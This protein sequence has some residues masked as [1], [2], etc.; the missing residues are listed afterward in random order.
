[1]SVTSKGQRESPSCPRGTQA[2]GDAGGTC[3]RVSGPGLAWLSPWGRGRAHDAVSVSTCDSF[4]CVVGAAEASPLHLTD[5]YTET[6]VAALPFLPPNHGCARRGAAGE[7]GEHVA[8]YSPTCLTDTGTRALPCR[9][10]PG[11]F[12]GGQKPDPGGRG[13]QTRGSLLHPQSLEPW[14]PTGAGLMGIPVPPWVVGGGGGEG[15]GLLGPCPELPTPTSSPVSFSFRLKPFLLRDKI[16]FNVP[17][18]NTGDSIYS[19]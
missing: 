13:E 9:P 6:N 12:V 10:K 19:L 17:R 3:R 15:S 14:A 8:P 4:S 2:G 1:M 11:C 18:G 5:N 16:F 7:Y